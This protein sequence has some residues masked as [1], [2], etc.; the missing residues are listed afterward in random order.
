MCPEIENDR[1]LLV[2]LLSREYC[3]QDG[4]QSVSEF[5][6]RFPTMRAELLRKLY[7]DH[8]RVTS[9]NQYEQIFEEYLSDETHASELNAQSELESLET[10]VEASVFASPPSRREEEKKMRPSRQ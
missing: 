5:A 6:D 8:D 10:C 7:G 9:G 4:V 1:V 3:L 2:K